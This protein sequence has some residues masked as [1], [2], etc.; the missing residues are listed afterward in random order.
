[1]RLGWTEQALA[2]SPARFIGLAAGN[3]H[4]CGVLPEET[5]QCWGNNQLG[6]L[7]NGSF[8]PSRVPVTVEGLTAVK[9]LVAHADQTCAVLA[10]GTVQCWGSGGVRSPQTE[11][12]IS[13]APIEIAW[14]KG[15]LWPT[16]G[17]THG[18]AVLPSREVFCQGSNLVGQL[19]AG[20]GVGPSS[21][22]PVRVRNILAAAAVA[23]G[24]SHTCAL[25]LD[26]TLTC[27]GAYLSPNG[28]FEPTGI[29]GLF[30]V[31][32]LAAGEQLTCAL[33]S[34]GR[35][36]CWGSNRFGQL[37][38][39]SSIDSIQPVAANGIKTAQAIA[40]GDYHACAL[41]QEGEVKCWGANILGQLGD[42]TTRNYPLPVAV[43]GLDRALAIVA[44][45]AHTCAIL[46]DQRVQC[47]G[48]NQ[49]GQLGNGSTTNAT[50]P[51]TVLGSE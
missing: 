8:E 23:A 30:S 29:G 42:G 20:V 43:Q 10:D 7:G 38:N 49:A 14:M 45:K 44:G 34:D 25:L 12:L 40:V 28:G 33:L 16:L 24:T 9:G 21:D 46:T 32:A 19:G 27:W 1:M 5:V 6:Q 39:G 51:V 48:Y 3:S 26:T 31:K 17:S 41:L 15:T 22:Q 18:C 2:R 35:V 36:G 50:S 13:P 47:W 11:T 37:G 4:T